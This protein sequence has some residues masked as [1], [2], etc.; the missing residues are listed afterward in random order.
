MKYIQS[1]IVLGVMAGALALTTFTGCKKEFLDLRP[2]TSLTPE[3]ALATEADLRVAMTGVYNGLRAVGTFGRTV[4]VLGDLMADNVYQH[5]QNSNRYTQYSRYAVAVNDGD[6]LGM[7]SSSYNTILRANNVINS[8]LTGTPGI[9][10]IKG[11]AKAVRALLYFNLVRFYARPFTDNPNGLGVPIVLTYDVSALPTRATVAEVYAQ[12]LK[13]LGEAFTEMTTF[14]N[15]SEMHKWAARALEAKVK[16]Y[17]NDMAG[18]LAAANDV[19]ANSTFTVV[20]AANYGAYWAS[21]T[22]RTDRVETLFEVSMDPVG[23]PGFDALGYIYNQQGYGDM[24]VSDD[25]FALFTDTDVRKALYQQSVAGQTRHPAVFVRKYLNIATDRDETKLLRMSDV[26]LIAAEASAAS[27]ATNA[28]N[29]LNYVVS[30][31]DPALAPYAST[32]AQLVTDIIAER[33][34]E[35]LAEG[36]RFHDLNRLKLTVNRS[37]NY[38]SDARTIPYNNFRRILPIPEGE[39]NANEAI[40]GQ[41]N[42]GYN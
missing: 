22:F 35:F 19:I 24:V 5:P 11:E 29:F 26:Y 41:Q 2:Y 7:W 3:D 4:P 13:D 18:A 23:N 8:P 1:K 32:G 15:S 6:A 27:N 40:R 12:I 33:R 21:A 20:T 28:Q 25:L 14:K 31:R 16:L 36:D 34:K 39:M 37:T 10:Q 38:P 9:N 30:R 17:Q 42:P